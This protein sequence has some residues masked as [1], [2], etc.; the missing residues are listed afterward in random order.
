MGSPALLCTSPEATFP[1]TMDL[2]CPVPTPT[3]SDSPGALEAAFLPRLFHELL[4]FL[5]SIAAP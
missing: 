3:R 2:R 4:C 5:V 1:P